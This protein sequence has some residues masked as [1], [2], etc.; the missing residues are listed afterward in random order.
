MLN[1]V[2]LHP[3]GER[4]KGFGSLAV[5]SSGG[6]EESLR[7]EKGS[8]DLSYLPGKR[9]CSYRCILENLYLFVDV[10]VHLPSSAS[11]LLI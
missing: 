9:S 8:V 10:V 2:V 7:V 5:V 3:L 4:R 11:R 6:V 1:T